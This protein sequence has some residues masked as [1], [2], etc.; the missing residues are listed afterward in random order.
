MSRRR[1]PPKR[2]RDPYG[3]NRPLQAGQGRCRNKVCNAAVWYAT[4]HQYDGQCPNC[5]DYS[6]IFEITKD[7]EIKL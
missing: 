7:W 6:R 3:K 5:N 2:Y 4:L 1:R